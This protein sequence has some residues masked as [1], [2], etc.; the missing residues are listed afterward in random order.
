MHFN[1]A[2]NVIVSKYTEYIILFVRNPQISAVHHGHHRVTS[3]NQIEGRP[4]LLFCSVLAG[5]SHLLRVGGQQ[6]AIA[7]EGNARCRCCAME[8]DNTNCVLQWERSNT[9]T[10]LCGQI[11]NAISVLWNLSV[12]HRAGSQHQ[13]VN[14]IEVKQNLD[15]FDLCI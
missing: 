4:G 11:G 13:P 8:A 12:Q 2:L 1:E 3:I 15:K 7:R 5:Q 9:D 6:W 10:A 14:S